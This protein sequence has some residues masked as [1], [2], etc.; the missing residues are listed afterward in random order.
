MYHTLP[1]RVVCPLR[2]TT[3]ATTHSPRRTEIEQKIESRMKESLRSMLDSSWALTQEEI[4]ASRKEQV[5]T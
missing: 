3:C 1:H 4:A 2:S 5:G